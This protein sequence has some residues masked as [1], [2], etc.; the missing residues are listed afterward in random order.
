MD[1]QVWQRLSQS[2]K[3]KLLARRSAAT[4]AKVAAS[5]S[6]AAR[7]SQLKIQQLAHRFAKQVML[8]SSAAL[9]CNGHLSGHM[10]SGTTNICCMLP[11]QHAAA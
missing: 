1:A 5:L 6:K 9:Q 2:I 4:Q 8:C 7:N 11:M 10:L 3:W